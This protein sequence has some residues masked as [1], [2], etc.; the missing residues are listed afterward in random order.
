MIFSPQLTQK[1]A[2]RGGT[3]VFCWDVAPLATLFLSE[4]THG[5]CRPQGWEQGS[6]ITSWS[7]CSA[8]THRH[9]HVGE[10]PLGR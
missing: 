8:A 4:D 10:T 6:R 1:S 2:S 9:P 3:H 5:C 7:A